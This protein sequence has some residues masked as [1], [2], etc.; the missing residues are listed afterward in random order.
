MPDELRPPKGASASKERTRTE[1]PICC[2]SGDV[3]FVAVERALTGRSHVVMVR[4][5]DILLAQLDMLVEAGICRSRSSAATFMIREGVRANSALFSKVKTTT[6][7]IA[8]LK[9]SLRASIGS[10]GNP[11]EQA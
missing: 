1:R 9:E 3:L 4:V 5:N 6:R 11:T 2:A 8:E 7:Q 10:S